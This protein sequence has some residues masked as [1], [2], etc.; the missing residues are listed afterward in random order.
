MPA[1]GCA[2]FESALSEEKLM[3]RAKPAMSDEFMYQRIVAKDRSYD[4]RFPTGVL[5]TGIY[6]LPSCPARKPKLENVRFF[7]QQDEAVAQGLRPCR[8]CRPELFYRGEDWDRS[9][10]LGLLRRLR[11]DPAH[12]TEIGDL[13]KACGIS[14]TKLNDLVRTEAHLTPA[15]LLHRERI[16]HAC[17]MLLAG[18]ERVIDIAYAVGYDGEATFHRQFLA[19]TGMTPGAYRD[20]HRSDR[21]QLQLPADFRV[22]EALAYHGRD[23]EGPAERRIGAD[24]LIKTAL[25]DGTATVLE[26]TFGKTMLDCR[27]SADKKLSPAA[28]AEA[29]RMLLRMIGLNSDS[30]AFEARG[31]RDAAIRRLTATQPGL[32]IPLT[33][34]TFEA[35][36]WAIIGQQINLAFATAL[37]RDLIELAGGQVPGTSGMRLHPDAATIAGLDPGDL[38]SRRFSR[39]KAAYLIDAAKL[40]AGGA[41][42]LAALADGS[43]RQAETQLLALRGLG[44]WTVNYVMLRGF[45]FADAVPVGDSA[46][47]TALQRFHGQ[48]TRPDAKETAT[49]MARFAPHRSLA[50]CHF[51]ASLKMAA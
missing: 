13:A 21:F 38:T 27:V 18:K 11:A 17:A 36:A 4:G 16:R 39:S 15:A 5:T 42:D 41:L 31:K 49:L 51:W 25:L 1:G 47:A 45:G 6:C 37:R 10:Y 28:M 7:G 33:P 40:V 30:T 22:E 23:K 26:L 19:A 44:P 3:V 14:S 50:T 35:L 32:R 24:R 34:T 12:Y 29:H 2:V 20:L 43:A 46:L 9:L 8:R 48:E